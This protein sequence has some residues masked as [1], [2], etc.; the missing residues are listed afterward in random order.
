M[1]VCTVYSLRASCD[2]NNKH[3]LYVMQVPVCAR[4][5]AASPCRD[6]RCALPR[7]PWHSFIFF[8]LLHL[9]SL[10]L[11]EEQ[12]W[13]HPRALPPSPVTCGWGWTGRIQARQW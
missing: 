10:F 5:P 9:L 12:R 3:L 2:E 11:K 13:S 6:P 7:H 8:N 4:G 1:L